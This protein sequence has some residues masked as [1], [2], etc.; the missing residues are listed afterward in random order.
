MKYAFTSLVFILFSTLFVNFNVFQS[1][2]LQRDLVTE[3]NSKQ[4]NSS[5]LSK[6]QNSNISIP[7]VTMTSLPLLPIYAA[8]RHAFGETEEAL[9][10]LNLKSK[11]ND[12]IGYRDALKSQIFYDLKVLDSSLFYAKKAYFKVPQNPIHFERLAIS[13]AYKKE[14]DSLIKYFT[15]FKH[16]DE[17][18][19]KLFL[20]SFL[21]MDGDY[22]KE[23]SSIAKKAKLKF[24]ESADISLY[25]NSILF[26]LENVKLAS[27]LASQAEVLYNESDF[28]K[29]AE[30]FEIASQKNPGVYSHYENAASSYLEVK[31]YKKALEYSSIVLDSFNIKLGKSE[32][33]KALSLSALDEN[34]DAC[35]FIRLSIKRGY[36][37]AYPFLNKFCE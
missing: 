29:A 2:I 32:F 24:P 25:S 6:L 35:A 12:Y 5:T 34:E 4:L 30:L 10:L 1:Y 21:A 11:D 20:V 9:D 16:E 15:S 18:I 22:P 8:Y 36:K 27:E 7:N 3:F 28:K 17:V 14:Q 31:N 19:W 23:V 26:G 13:L 37:T 33:V